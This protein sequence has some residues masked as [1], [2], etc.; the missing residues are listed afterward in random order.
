MKKTGYA[1]ILSLC[2]CAIAMIYAGDVQRELGEKL[3]RLHIVA[4]SN[5]EADQKI[6][7]EVRDSILKNS[8]G[9][10]TYE[11]LAQNAKNKLSE[12]GAGYTA[13]AS[14][15]EYYV[16]KKSY[17]NLTLPGGMYKCLRVV[18]GEG[19]GENWWCVAYPP[20]CFSEE[21]FGGLSEEGERTLSE[22]LDRKTL[23]AIVDNGEVNLRFKIVEIA[24]NIK[25]R[26]E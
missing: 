18:L 8:T 7:L 25:T 1:L 10:T 23:N 12:L 6:K 21:V 17:K 3:L 15:G 16:P 24:K 26:I 19:K 4:N 11:E 20:L 9:D 14:V 13:S 5:S 22:I 2:I